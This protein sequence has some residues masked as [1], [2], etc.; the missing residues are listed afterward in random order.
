[1][2]VN[3][4]AKNH[5]V[6][7]GKTTSWLDLAAIDFFDCQDECRSFFCGFKSNKEKGLPQL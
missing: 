1:M 6:L 4:K 7:A 5:S 3:R 2:F